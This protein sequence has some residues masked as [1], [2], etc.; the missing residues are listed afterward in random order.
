MEKKKTTA[1]DLAKSIFKGKDLISKAQH[2]AHHV[3]QTHKN[4]GTQAK[5][6]KAKTP[7]KAKPAEKETTATKTTK[8]AFSK[9]RV[10]KS[11]DKKIQIKSKSAKRAVAKLTK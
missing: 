1:K 9:S 11:L 6:Q 5:T 4:A 3:V 2:K 10:L 8:S 7:A